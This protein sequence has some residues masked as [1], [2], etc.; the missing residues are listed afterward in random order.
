MDEQA[1]GTVAS[2][3]N[4]ANE[5]PGKCLPRPLNHQHVRKCCNFSF[6]SNPIDLFGAYSESENRLSSIVKVTGL[7]VSERDDLPKKICS[8]HSNFQS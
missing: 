7:G 5:T 2:N 8:I 6:V 4:M 1:L 3:T